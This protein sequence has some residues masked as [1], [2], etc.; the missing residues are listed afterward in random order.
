MLRSFCLAT[1]HRWL[2]QMKRFWTVVS[3]VGLAL[4]SGCQ[5]ET[6]APP[7]VP[8]QNV[9]Q[10]PVE[11]SKEEHPTSAKSLVTVDE[12][13]RKSLDGIPYDVWFD[14]PLAVAGDSAAVTSPK[15][16]TSEPQ[17]ASL[18]TP[19]TTS[20]PEPKSPEQTET[21]SEAWADF[22]DPD[23]LVDETKKL[24]NQ[25]KGLLQTLAT[26]NEGFETVKIDGAVLAAL[27]TIATELPGDM[28]WKS[29]APYIRDY[30]WEIVESAQGLGKPN[31]DKARLA[32]ENLQAVFSG[33]IPVDATEP[34]SERPFPDIAPRVFLMKRMK[35]AFTSLKMNIN[36]AEKLSSE[37]D[38]ALHE[39]MV[40]AALT[41]VVSLKDYTSAD[42]PDYQNFMQVILTN[43]QSAITAVKDQQF[44]QFSNALNVIDKA[45]LNCH[46]AYKE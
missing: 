44:D 46:S 33:T 26:Y 7:T 2:N 43:C 8:Q 23:Q 39:T 12:K 35:L 27:A 6:P 15:I 10:V 22:I 37:Q 41:K 30:G 25:L 4:F 19:T 3:P 34:A 36:T 18:S 11:K 17:V 40:L 13:G 28:S 20:S 42:E 9:S 21:G 29:N 24:R 1:V 31:F 5:S 32:Y 16:V 14:D 38:E 45:C